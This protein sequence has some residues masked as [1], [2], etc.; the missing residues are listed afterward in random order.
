VRCALDGE[1][2][3]F[4]LPLRVRLRKHALHVLVPRARA[5]DTSQRSGPQ[6]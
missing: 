5:R 3:K 4:L 2:R 6:A 1:V